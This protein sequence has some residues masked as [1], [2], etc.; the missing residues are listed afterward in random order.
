MQVCGVIIHCKVDAQ[1][2]IGFASVF[3]THWVVQHIIKVRFGQGLPLWTLLYIPEPKTPEPKTPEPKTPEPN[4]TLDLEPLTCAY[5]PR[6][7]Y[8]LLVITSDK[9]PLFD[10]LYSRHIES[11]FFLK[12]NTWT[13]DKQDK[14]FWSK[15][16]L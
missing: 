1:P 15:H 13:S 8:C 4:N 5:F 11:V 16:G 12:D 7:I 10:F 2:R 14:Q 6:L 3:C 9:L